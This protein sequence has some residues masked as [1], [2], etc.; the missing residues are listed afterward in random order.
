MSPVG[1]RASSGDGL[2][3]IVSGDPKRPCVKCG[4]PIGLWFC[5][6]W[7]DDCIDHYYPETK[8]GR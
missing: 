6:Q 4:Q 3:G 1:L 2:M 5:A 7:C 8:R